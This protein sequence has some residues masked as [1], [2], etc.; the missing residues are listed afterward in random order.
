MPKNEAAYT[1]RI[2]AE[3]LQALAEMAER[4]HR[5]LAGKLREMI[6]RELEVG[7]SA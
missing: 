1:L 2:E 7:T 6:D 3:K 5:T 4:E